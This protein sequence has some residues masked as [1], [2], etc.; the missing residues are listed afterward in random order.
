MTR[1]RTMGIGIALMA[2][3]AV[4]VFALGGSDR[5]EAQVP[6][7]MLGTLTVTGSA[8]VGAPPDGASIEVQISSLEP[9]AT[10]AL[11][12]GATALELVRAALAEEGVADEDLQTVRIRLDEEHDYTDEGRVSIGFRFSNTIR[13]TLHGTDTIGDVIDVAVRAGGDA[14]SINRIQFLV[15]N[16]VALEDAARL[17]AID[18]ARRKATAMAERAG[19]SLAGVTVIEEIGFATPVGIEREEAAAAD[20]AAFAL[21]NTPVFGGEEQVTASVRIVFKIY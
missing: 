18:E 7:H 20:D 2:A 5:A 1:L 16:R 8:T 17:A 19:V 6:A 14:V 13:V 15:S 4:G 3:L 11:A 12:S 10:E 9:S 21:A